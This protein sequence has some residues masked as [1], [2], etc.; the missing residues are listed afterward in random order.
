MLSAAALADVLTD[1]RA[2]DLGRDVLSL[3]AAFHGNPCTMG[4]YFCSEKTAQCSMCH[5]FCCSLHSAK[6]VDCTGHVCTRCKMSWG[7]VLPCYHHGEMCPPERRRRCPK[8]TEACGCNTKPTSCKTNGRRCIKCKVMLCPNHG[9]RA[10]C[11]H[12]VHG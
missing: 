8:H 11:M 4:L 12:C 6:C 5:N 1:T 2:G 3:I 9:D 7:F 10:L